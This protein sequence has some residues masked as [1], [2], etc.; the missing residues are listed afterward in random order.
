MAV[1]V[2]PRGRAS[3]GQ[4]LSDACRGCDA[5]S[6]RWLADLRDR[7]H[8]GDR[9]VQCLHSQLLRMAYA[10]L[11]SWHPPPPRADLDDIAVEAADDAV[12]AV[13]AHLDDFRGASRFTTWACQFALTEVSGAMRKRR[14]RLCEVPVEPD[15]IVVLAGA[16]G[17]VER[18]FEQAE[19]LRCLVAV[20]NDGQ[21]L[22]ARQRELVLALAIAGDSVEQ[23]ACDRGA[24]VGALYKSL[25][26][27]RQKLR[28]HVQASGFAT[29]S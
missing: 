1:Q 15:V 20:V 9:A 22:S 24:T 8:A 23:L 25:H 4:E 2:A 28:A 17:S 3:Q 26:D 12:V 6:C 13:L 21:L 5:D 29:V 19:L 27:A 14:R 16:R 18:E 11:L 10:R 7:G